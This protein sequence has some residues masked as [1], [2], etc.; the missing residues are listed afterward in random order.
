MQKTEV[1]TI[2]EVING[3]DALLDEVDQRVMKDFYINP[4]DLSSPKFEDDLDR[5]FR[6]ENELMPGNLQK[7]DNSLDLESI[8]DDGPMVVDVPSTDSEPMPL[9]SLPSTVIT[10]FACEIIVRPLSMI[11]FEKS[12]H[13]N[14]PSSKSHSELPG[15]DLEKPITLPNSRPSEDTP[16]KEVILSPMLQ[17]STPESSESEEIQEYSI[18]GDAI[19]YE[20][21]EKIRERQLWQPVW[22]LVEAG[23]PFVTRSVYKA[24]SYCNRILGRLNGLNHKRYRRDILLSLIG[25]HE[26]NQAWVDAAKSYERYLEEFAANDLYPFEDHEDAPTGS[27]TSRQD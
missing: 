12:I 5:P 16:R 26:K 14:F 7:Q 9:N 2:E 11:F 20:M 4:S 25:M 22:L 8:I 17:K 27:L 6:L 24:T 19:D 10:T 13:C 21:K 3:I 23:N 15:D 18:L 1:K